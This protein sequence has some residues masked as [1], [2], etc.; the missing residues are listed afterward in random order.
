MFTKLF[1]PLKIAIYVQNAKLG[2]PGPHFLKE[3]S[4]KQQT[5]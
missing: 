1:F 5:N 4:N 3:T 2:I